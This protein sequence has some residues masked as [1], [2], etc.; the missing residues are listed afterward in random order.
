MT[1][2][3]TPSFRRILF[4]MI[5]RQP[6]RYAA[7]LFLWVS[8]WTLPILVGLIAARY[9]DALAQGMTA[10]TLTFVVTAMVVYA[11]ATVVRLHLSAEYALAE[12]S[13][14]DLVKYFGTTFG[15][16]R[17]WRRKF[18]LLVC[19]DIAD[20]FGTFPLTSR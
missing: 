20:P 9:F 1:Q 15:T 17:E 4:G 19:D 6:I 11:L 10:S 2:Q 12:F 7:A 14:G 13:S 8:V 3:V 16:A 18:K 5:R